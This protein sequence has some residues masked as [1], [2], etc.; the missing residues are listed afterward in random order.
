M[1]SFDANRHKASLHNQV[2]YK[3]KELIAQSSPRS[4]RSAA[5]MVLQGNAMRVCLGDMHVCPAE[6]GHGSMLMQVVLTFQAET[7]GLHICE[8]WRR[9][10]MSV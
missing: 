6:H 10:R 8:N 9:V 2:S 3:C 5:R 7:D 4:C 1:L